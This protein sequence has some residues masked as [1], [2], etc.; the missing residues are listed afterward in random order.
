MTRA[1]ALA[2]K[3]RMVAVLR[4]VGSS[5]EGEFL[6]V[7][8]CGEHYLTATEEGLANAL[9]VARQLARDGW[10]TRV[11]GQENANERHCYSFGAHRP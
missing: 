5:L 3:P 7:A 1:R 4:S 6:V 10:D 9:W 8:S 11:Q 2:Y